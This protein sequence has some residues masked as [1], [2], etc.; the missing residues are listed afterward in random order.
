MDKTII[1]F[2]KALEEAG[3]SSKGAHKNEQ[4]LSTVKAIVSMS[5]EEFADYIKANPNEKVKLIYNEYNDWI[6]S[7][8][9]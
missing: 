7:Y 5:K 6:Q 4:F 8:V 1:D 3:L 2:A 9:G